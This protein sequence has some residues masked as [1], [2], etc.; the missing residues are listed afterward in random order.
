MT[1]TG[2]ESLAKQLVGERIRG[3]NYFEIDYGA[4]REYWNQDS[5][6]DSLDFGLDLEMASGR[7][8]GIIWGSEFVQ[9]GISILPFSLHSEL[10]TYHHVDVSDQSRWAGYIGCTIENVQI[11]WANGVAYRNGKYEGEFYPQELIL[12]F[13]S[14]GPVCIAALEIRE[15]SHYGMSDNITVFF[16]SSAAARYR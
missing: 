1:R 7:I 11:A 14:G 9:Y 12:S 13:S 4:G 15:S 2:F 5:E 16:D 6:Y 8:W 10:G 3:V